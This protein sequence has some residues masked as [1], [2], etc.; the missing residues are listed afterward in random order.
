MDCG[1]NHHL[2]HFQILIDTHKILEIRIQG[3]I[4]N[5]EEIKVERICLK[6][7]E[8]NEVSAENMKKFDMDRRWRLLKSLLRCM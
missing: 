1:I 6:C 4:E 7:G 2:G 3:E 8:V 5:M